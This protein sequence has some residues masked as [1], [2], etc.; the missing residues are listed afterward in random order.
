MHEKNTELVE[1][2]HQF[3]AIWNHQPESLHKTQ[4]G[5]GQDSVLSCVDAPFA[6]LLRGVSGSGE[7]LQAQLCPNLAACLGAIS[8]GSLDKLCT[9]S[10]QLVDAFSSFSDHDECMSQSIS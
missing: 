9:A 5:F 3:K 8:L 7:G 10:P 1:S 2:L 4:R 6:S